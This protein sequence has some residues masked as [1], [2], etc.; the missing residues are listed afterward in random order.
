M[1]RPEAPL[2]AYQ[3]GLPIGVREEEA[4]LF[5]VVKGEADT[6]RIE[7]P[8]MPENLLEP[9]F[10]EHSLLILERKY[11]LRDKEGR[12]IETPREMIWR[13][14]GSIGSADLF[15]G[16]DPTNAREDFYLLM[17]NRW[18]VPNS[19]TI[20][21]A[22]TERPQL[23]AC[24]VI[25]IEDRMESIIEARNEMTWVHKTGGGTGFDFSKLRPKDSPLSTGGVA[26]GPIPFMEEFDATTEAVKQGGRRRGANMAILRVDHP[27]IRE[28]IAAKTEEEKLK[29]F[30]ISVGV[31]DEYMRLVKERGEYN[32]VDP[33]TGKEKKGNAREIF[34]KI[35]EGA[36][37]HADPGLVFLD[38][39][40]EANPTPHLGEIEATNP[41]GEQPLL[42]YES[43]NLG[44]INLALMVE[45]GEINRD[46]LE[47]VV[48]T[49]VHFL[50][51]V[52]DMN[53]FPDPKIEEATLK[54]RKIGLGVM[55]FYDMLVAL[56]IRYDSEEAIGVAE[57]I[58][59][60]IRAKGHEASEKLAKK[61]GPFPAYRGSIYEKEGRLMRNATVT[62]VAPTGTISIIVGCN[63]GIEPLFAFRTIRKDT[64]TQ[65]GKRIIHPQFEEMV[66]EL[67]LSEE[68]KARIAEQNSLE[69]ITEIPEKWKEV[70][71][72]AHDIS[73]E[74]HLRI[75]AAF[76][77][78][79]D[80]GVSKTINLPREAT[81]ED[82]WKAY[83]L[84]W[85]LGCKGITV[86]RYGSKE[87]QVLSLEEKEKVITVRQ[88]RPRPEITRGVT[89]KIVVGC[90]Q[91]LY[92]TINEDELGACEVFSQ[93]G[94]SGGCLSSQ[95]ESVGR[96]ISLA[97]R[98]GID[99]KAIIKQL[100]GI[101]CPAPKWREGQMIL[102]CGDAI[103]QVM[104]RYLKEKEGLF[105]ESSL[106]DKPD[107]PKDVLLGLSLEC[108]ECGS[109]VEYLD[110]CRVCP[111]CG[112]SQCL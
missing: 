37:G 4:P 6:R 53:Q 90:G 2:G 107:V 15:Y 68:I 10:S 89:E 56:G 97:L 110:G 104:E 26:S 55:G 25:P 50:D 73:P 105:S 28:F 85:E 40:N 71:R 39:L 96:L 54:T 46:R 84:A 32:L 91:T 48:K 59:G 65:E 20:M 88:P 41:C 108:S 22:G 82:V 83:M 80:S 9:E 36:W 33:H 35:V 100:R 3:Y 38:R 112:F 87:K 64:F 58:M 27:D 12:V 78:H 98:S 74:W 95:S 45:D 21:N 69:G 13:M 70:L 79:T 14:A 18:F 57:E 99:A 76:Q 106:F 29:N 49:A 24:F 67:D 60:F 8:P 63:S 30:N 61:R 34:K 19:P 77:R 93:M 72:T 44:S 81:V 31:T 47:W 51:N 43:C 1:V 23:S 5:R 111:A 52:I 17:A 86:Y 66:A 109:M 7:I 103:A 102:S 75:Q 94:K 101:R 16:E 92:V 11:L 42:P 62:T